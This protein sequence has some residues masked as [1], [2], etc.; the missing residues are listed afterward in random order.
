MDNSEKYG[1][2]QSQKWITV[3]TM[4]KCMR[5]CTALR[6]NEYSP[7]MYICVENARIQWDCAGCMLRSSMHE[8][9]TALHIAKTGAGSSPR[10]P[11]ADGREI[12]NRL[13]KPCVSTARSVSKGFLTR[14]ADCWEGR[15]NSRSTRRSYTKVC[16][17]AK[18]RIV[19]G[20]TS[21]K[22]RAFEPF[23]PT[24]VL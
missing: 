6:G 3:W 15:Q 17:R 5:L 22:E 4:W 12:K 10:M 2:S 16:D 11:R 14:C 13:L 19:C 8:S 7:V 1:V 21:I 18:T 24:I 9:Q 20:E 23:L